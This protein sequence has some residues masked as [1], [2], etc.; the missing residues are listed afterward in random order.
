MRALRTMRPDDEEHEQA[1]SANRCTSN[2]AGIPPD[3]HKGHSFKP[4]ARGA[5]GADAPRWKSIQHTS[6]KFICR[7]SRE[8]C[9][10]SPPRR[11]CALAPSHRPQAAPAPAA[12]KAGRPCCIIPGGAPGLLAF[13]AACLHGRAGGAATRRA[14]PALQILEAGAPRRARF[15]RRSSIPEVGSRRSLHIAAGWAALWAAPTSP[16]PQALHSSRRHNRHPPLLSLQQRTRVLPALKPA[17]SS[18]A[19]FFM[20]FLR[21]ALGLFV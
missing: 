2:H 14:L 20:P 10:F 16:P 5:E 7:I 11:P 21:R 4:P 12:Y 8:G 1:S 6:R 15:S 13:V 9:R 3:F 19:G 18:S 17:A